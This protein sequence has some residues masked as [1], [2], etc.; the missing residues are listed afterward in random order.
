M[1]QLKFE[2]MMGN[3][4]IVRIR[5]DEIGKHRVNGE[6]VSAKITGVESAGIWI[7]HDGLARDISTVF[8][9]RIADLPKASAHIFVPFSSIVWAAYL[10]PKLDE[11]SFGV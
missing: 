2:E 8:G 3:T 10:S 4:V 1:P 11:G 9:V 7:E 5:I 6:T